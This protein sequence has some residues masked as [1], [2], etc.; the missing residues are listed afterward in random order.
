MTIG[1][2]LCYNDNMENDNGKKDVLSDDEIA[3]LSDDEAL[4]L[5]EKNHKKF[6]KEDTIV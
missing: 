4:S 3:A 5:L 1:G 6:L 2:F